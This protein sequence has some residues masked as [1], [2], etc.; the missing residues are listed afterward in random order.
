M[1]KFMGSLNARDEMERPELDSLPEEVVMVILSWLPVD[2]LAQ[3]VRVC[4]KWR[5]TAKL[6]QVWRLSF[7]IS[8][9]DN[10]VGPQRYNFF[11]KLQ[12]SFLGPLLTTQ[13]FLFLPFC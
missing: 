4:K 3:N 13:H 10:P 7:A 1:K 5:D 6:P 11:T 8:F 9:G 12:P 2:S